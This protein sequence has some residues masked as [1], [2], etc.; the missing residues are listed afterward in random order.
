MNPLWKVVGLVSGSAAGFV[1]QALVDVIWEKGLKQ[2]K[3][4]GKSDPE[5]SA[6]QLAAF[7]AVTAAVNAVV[8]AVVNQKMSASYGK[9]TISK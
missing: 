6:F 2:T 3:P 4:K 1:S 7:A 9:K 8:M 5:K